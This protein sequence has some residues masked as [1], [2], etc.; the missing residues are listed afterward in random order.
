MRGSSRT[1]TK[2]N[3]DVRRSNVPIGQSIDRSTE[4]IIVVKNGTRQEKIQ[5]LSLLPSIRYSFQLIKHCVSLL[6]AFAMT[7]SSHSV[8]QSHRIQEVMV[9]VMIGQLT[10][11]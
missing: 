3:C 6:K 10:V 7:D 9:K 2:E 1:R 5:K 4:K 11:C 8:L